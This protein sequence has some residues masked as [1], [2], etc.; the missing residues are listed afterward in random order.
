MFV[1]VRDQNG[2]IEYMDLPDLTWELLSPDETCS[3]IY[4]VDYEPDDTYVETTIELR[5]SDGMNSYLRKT[6][7]GS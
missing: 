7:F 4:V 6:E 1:R 3:A 5:W 2:S